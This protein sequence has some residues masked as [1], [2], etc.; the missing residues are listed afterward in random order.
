MRR[1]FKVFLLFLSLWTIGLL[2]PYLVIGPLYG[3]V[4]FKITMPFSGTLENLF[5]I[6]RGNYFLILLA[7]ILQ[8]SWICLVVS[9]IHCQSSKFEKTDM[10]N[11]PPDNTVD[12]FGSTDPREMPSH[13]FWR[14]S[15]LDYEN[16]IR[17]NVEEQNY[18]VCPRHWYI[19]AKIPCADCDNQFLFS[20]EEQKHWYEKLKFYVDSF[21]DRCKPCQKAS[22]EMHQQIDY[23]QNHYDDPKKSDKVKTMVDEVVARYGFL[24]K[25]LKDPRFG[26][27]SPST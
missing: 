20:K 6:G 8:G 21:P 27:T 10:D 1:L 11:E 9:F 26:L 14:A 18:S 5:G 24:P 16:A 7:T 19:D 13:L 23:I 12:S 2:A 22:K 4:W 15:S 25:P 17:A 3:K